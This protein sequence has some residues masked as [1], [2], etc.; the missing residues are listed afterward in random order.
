MGRVYW[1]AD[2]LSMALL[3]LGPKG[4]NRPRRR[5]WTQASVAIEGIVARRRKEA[6]FRNVFGMFVLQ[7]FMKNSGLAACA[8]QHFLDS[9]EPTR[10]N[11]N[12]CDATSR[13]QVKF[14]VV[15]ELSIL[16]IF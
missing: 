7:K 4:R 16:D 8:L 11:G 15:A 5:A 3:G 2:R 10:Q 13:A 9:R 6:R 12:C 1:V 14:A